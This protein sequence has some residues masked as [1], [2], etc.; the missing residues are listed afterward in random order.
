[1]PL[2]QMGRFTSGGKTFSIKSDIRDMQKQFGSLSRTGFKR[3]TFRA[4][5]RSLTKS[6]T[7]T[8]KAIAAKRNLLSR[9]VASGM[10]LK[11]ANM[12]DLSAAI[13]GRGEM[14]PL[15]AVKGTKTQKALGV[16]VAPERGHR[17]V[18]KDSF[19]SRMPSGHVGIFKR[20]KEGAGESG[21]VGRLG[22]QELTMPSIAHTLQNKDII[23]LSISVF[24][25]SFRVAFANQLNNE[26]R[27]A[28]GGR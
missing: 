15:F 24:Q 18:I 25:S 16:S 9:T 1:M 10:S 13:I 19:I 20:E 3:A 27:K 12:L 21:R 6:N 11:K 26:I 17:Q 28:R 23:A 14:I 2:K 5:N 7:A 4:I 22:I 8:K